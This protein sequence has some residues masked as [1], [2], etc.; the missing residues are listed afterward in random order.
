MTDHNDSFAIALR[1]VALGMISENDLSDD[2][3]NDMLQDV[4][5]NWNEEQAEWRDKHY[6]FDHE[7]NHVWILT[8]PIGPQP[9]Y[10]QIEKDK[11]PQ[12][13]I[14]SSNEGDET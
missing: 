13:W 10:T 5:E 9:L 4:W 8:Y 12:N 7:Y 6:G 1:K 3:I 2:E 11:L 14:G